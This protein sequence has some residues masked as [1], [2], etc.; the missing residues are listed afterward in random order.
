MTFDQ[1]AA[2]NRIL[3]AQG[4]PPVNTIDG[5]TS[6]NTQIALSMLRQASTDIQ[7]EGWAFNTEYEYPLSV[8]AATGFINIPEN[9]TRWFSDAEP[10]L[11][12]RG[13][14][15]YNRQ[16]KTYIFT[17]AVDGTAQF[18]LEWNELPL[19]AKTCIA[20][21]AARVTYEQYVGADETRQNLYLEEKNATMVLD[22]READ[23][24]HASMLNDATLPYLKGSS[25]V[26]GSP[27][28]PSI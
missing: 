26:P 13:S 3:A 15:L 23:T 9:I 27:R 18:E 22:Q 14:R 19:E 10:W 4:L 25:Y 11:I 20:A 6:K 2:V 1:L 12:Q 28:Y 8:D 7:S 16:D 17:T 21:R 5:D 24:G